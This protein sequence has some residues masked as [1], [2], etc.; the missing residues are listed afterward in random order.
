MKLYEFFSVTSVD[1]ER[2]DNKGKLDDENREKIAN[3]LF[4][5]ILDHDRLHKEHF[6][7]IARDI[8]RQYK[9]NK[10]VDRA[11]FTEC[12]M[13]MVREACLEF[14]KE[15]QMK[16]NPK[17]VFDKEFCKGVCE[18]LAEKHIDDITKNRYKLGD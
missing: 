4:W 6:L 12:W 8:H 13:P 14:H 11:D 7:P 9:K 5:F 17:S 3:D 10:K 2:E 1:P 15:H 16:G 18:R